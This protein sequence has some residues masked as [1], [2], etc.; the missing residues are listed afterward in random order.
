MS[1]NSII[2]LFMCPTV[3]M[4]SA[5]NKTETKGRSVVNLINQIPTS[6][7]ENCGDSGDG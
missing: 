2:A 6:E 1:T 4:F 7:D 3:I 5:T